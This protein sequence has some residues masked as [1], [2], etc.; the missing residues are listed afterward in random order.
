MLVIANQ[1]GFYNG[2]RYR[3]GQVF[4]AQ[5]GAAAKWFDPVAT[6]SVEVAV[7][8][9]KVKAEKEVEKTLSEAVADGDI[10]ST[11]EML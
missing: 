1:I 11:F 4:E 7:K 8:K 2:R 9:T 5:D 6:K 10:G 3:A